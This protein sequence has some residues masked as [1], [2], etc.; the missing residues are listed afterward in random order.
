MGFPAT[1]AVD[2]WRRVA[3]AAGPD[4]R[5]HPVEDRLTVPNTPI[6]ISVPEIF[7]E[8]DRLERRAATRPGGPANPASSS[9]S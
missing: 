3:Y 2:P 8:L 6:A 5:L 7:A 1:W 9:T 4:G